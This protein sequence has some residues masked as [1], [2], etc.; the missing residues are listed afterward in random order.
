METQMREDTMRRPEFG[1]RGREKVEP[2]KRKATTLERLM[3]S[4]WWG[5]SGLPMKRVA[6]AKAFK[7]KRP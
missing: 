7:R 2:A 4:R 5:A 1:K 6:P 3:G